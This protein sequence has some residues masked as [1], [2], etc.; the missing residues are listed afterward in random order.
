MFS[1]KNKQSVPDCERLIGPGVISFLE[2]KGHTSGA[3]IIRLIHNWHKAVDGRG[4]SEEQRSTYCRD[5]KEW[6]LSD[7]MP[8]YSPQPDFSTID[9]NRWA[10]NLL[11]FVEEPLMIL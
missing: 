6:L 11:S 3:S 7:W 1:G 10:I 4:L 5:M 9:V 2:G 8:W